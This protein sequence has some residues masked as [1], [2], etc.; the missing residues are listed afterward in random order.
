MTDYLNEI[1]VVILAGGLA[2]RLGNLTKDQSKSMLKIQGMPFLEYQLGFLRKGGIKNVVIC[3]GHLREQIEN[4]CGD[5]RKHEVNIRYSYEDNLLGTAG[6]LK[7]AEPLLGDIFFTMYGDSYLFLDFAAVMRYFQSQ[8]KLALMTVYRNQGRFD[9]SNT[10]V[11]GNLVK[12][13]SKRGKSA[14]MVYIDYGVNAF[15]KEVLRMVPENQFYGL[16][17]LF[18]RLI[19]KKEL[20]AFAVKERFYEVGSLSGLKDFEEYI[21]T[22]VT[23]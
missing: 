5:G 10:V 9:S 21:M 2:T 12:R 17:D 4:Y 23:G 15:R 1:Q 13:Y 11:D 6:A 19:E 18:P 8:H 16:E 14:D 3:L 22:K 7:K 20:L